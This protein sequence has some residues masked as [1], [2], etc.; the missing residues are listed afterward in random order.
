MAMLASCFD[1]SG[2]H[3]GSRVTVVTVATAASAAGP[4]GILNQ[5]AHDIDGLVC[6]T[7]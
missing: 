6:H 1:E 3:E 2:S 4:A 7:C 5:Q